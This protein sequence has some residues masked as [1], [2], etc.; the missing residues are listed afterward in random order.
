MSIYFPAQYNI[1]KQRLCKLY[2]LDRN[3]Y[4][5]YHLK[6]D[7]QIGFYFEQNIGILCIYFVK[8]FLSRFSVVCLFVCLI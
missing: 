6:I 5:K 1:L 3:T 4:K 2:I 8:F 7:Q